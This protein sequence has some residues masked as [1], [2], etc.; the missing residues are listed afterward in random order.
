MTRPLLPRGWAWRG[1]A[2]LLP[3][4]LAVVGFRAGVRVTYWGDMEA[5]GLLTQLYAAAGL[6][7]LGGMDLGMPVGGPAPARAGVWFAYFA[8]PLITTGA[9]AEGIL[10]TVRPS[11]LQLRGLRQHVVLVGLGSLGTLYL[12]GLRDADPRRQVLVVD[13]SGGGANASEAESRRG[14]RLLRADVSHRRARRSLGLERAAGVVIMTKDDLVNLEAAWDVLD[15][16]PD[17]RVIVHVADIA[18]RRRLGRLVD[19]GETRVRAFNSHRIAA[20]RLW[21]GALEARFKA[22]TDE[23]AVVIAGFGRFGQTI[24]E[25]LRE[26]AGDELGRVVVVDKVASR[27]LEAF[28]EHVAGGWHDPRFVAVDGDV[29]D[30][31]T[32]EAVHNAL[33]ETRCSP[34]YVLGVDDDRTNLRAAARVR[35]EDAHAPAFVRCFHESRFIEEMATEYNFEVLSLERLLREAFHDEHTGWFGRR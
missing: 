21:T 22:T 33:G 6:F 30:P 20:R 13:R 3:F 35:A 5:L 34:S 18:M 27:Q 10:R 31:H 1:A 14:V 15:D 28:T 11:W 32:W 12:Q 23:D 4:A 24:A 16:Y 2:L 17:T 7:V 26:Q 25:F 8:A 9:V 29:D 19:Q